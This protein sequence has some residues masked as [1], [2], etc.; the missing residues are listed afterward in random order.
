MHPCDTGRVKSD[1]DKADDLSLAVP[2]MRR[3]ANAA[4]EALLT[5]LAQLRDG[6][7]WHG[8]T[9]ARLEPLLREPAPESGQDP[10][11]VLERAVADVL[12]YA[13]RV[14]H[15]RFFA[16]VPSAPPWPGIK[17]RPE[18]GVLVAEIGLNETPLTALAGGVP[19]DLVAGA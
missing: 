14:D 5:R 4:T 19:M 10:L 15:P 6:A 9:R 1:R 17:V 13:A 18:K 11:A 8:A 2:E 3:L 16:F 7:P 12:P